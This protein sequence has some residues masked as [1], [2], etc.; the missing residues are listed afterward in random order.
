MN[1]N[2]GNKKNR[3]NLVFKGFFLGFL[4]FALLL[5]AVLL[6]GSFVYHNR[7]TDYRDRYFLMQER[8]IVGPSKIN[9]AVL[10]ANDVPEATSVL[11]SEK[12]TS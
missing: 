9:Q 12:E 3:R 10:N 7:Y 6:I 1:D 8:R 5:S 11:L 2:T 4:V